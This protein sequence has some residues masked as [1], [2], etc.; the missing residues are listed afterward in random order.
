MVL[1][2]VALAAASIPK[3][4][5]IIPAVLG[6]SVSLS[7]SIPQT[8]QL[9]WDSIVHYNQTIIA[10]GGAIKLQNRQNQTKFFIQISG[11][12]QTL[13]IQ[14][15]T[16]KDD[17]TYRCADLQNVNYKESFKVNI[18]G[19]SDTTEN[20]MPAESVRIEITTTLL[21]KISHCNKEQK[22][23]RP[24]QPKVIKY[25]HMW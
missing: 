17:G 20:N 23:V 6:N 16:L 3:Q 2:C 14:S 10:L 22:S 12:N 18:L 5:K 9:M 7:C 24:T 25:H 15:L 4:E 11:N 21:Y 19:K 1:V 8:T 13:V